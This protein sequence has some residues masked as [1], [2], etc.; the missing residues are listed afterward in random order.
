MGVGSGPGVAVGV[1]TGLGV[2][3][4]V[5]TGLGVAVAVGTAWVG[6]GD[7]V[8]RGGR[9]KHAEANSEADRMKSRVLI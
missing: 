5:G 3:V 7:G 4:G 6:V 8:G 2:A 1:G 9:P